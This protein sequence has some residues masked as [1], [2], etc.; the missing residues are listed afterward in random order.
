MAQCAWVVM[1]KDT[2]EHAA[3]IREV[4]KMGVNVAEYTEASLRQTP[5]PFVVNK[6]TKDIGEANVTALA[7]KKTQSLRLVVLDAQYVPEENYVFK[8]MVQ[9]P[10]RMTVKKFALSLKNHLR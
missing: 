3:F 1:C 4:K 5:L 8:Y 10:K 6:V 7:V 2:R 9:C